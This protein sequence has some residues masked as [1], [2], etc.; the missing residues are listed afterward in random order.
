[1]DHQRSGN[2]GQQDQEG[3]AP[4]PEGECDGGNMVGKRTP[5][6]RI[7]CPEERAQA[8]QDIRRPIPGLSRTIRF[9]CQCFEDVSPPMAGIRF[10][11]ALRLANSASLRK[12][13]TFS[14][15][16]QPKAWNQYG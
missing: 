14:P 9:V 15:R 3:N 13:R 12:A 2:P 7:A 4:A 10:Q 6:Y 1:M 11:R 8:Q 5:Q 16:T